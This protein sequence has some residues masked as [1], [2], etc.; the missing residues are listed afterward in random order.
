MPRCAKLLARGSCAVGP[1]TRGPFLFLPCRRQGIRLKA[2]AILNLRVP[3]QLRPPR[4]RFRFSLLCGAG[5]RFLD[6]RRTARQIGRRGPQ[7][8]FRTV[9][10]ETGRTVRIPVPVRRGCFSGAERDGVDLRAR[11][12]RSAGGRHRLLRL[13]RGRGQNP[14]SGRRH[15]SQPR[16]DRAAQARR[17]AGHKSLNRLETVRQLERLGIADLL[18][19]IHITSM[20]FA[21]RFTALRTSWGIPGGRRAR[22][23]DYF[24]RQRLLQQR[25]RPFRRTRALRRVD[26][27]ADLRSAN[28][29]SSPMRCAMPVQASV[30]DSSQDWPQIS[31]EEMVALAAGSSGL[32]DS[33][34]RR[35]CRRNV[36]VLAK[37]PGW[38][39][40]TR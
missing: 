14:Q 33:A 5:L 22:C 23:G 3:T 35:R 28:T 24:A 9:S 21:A 6:R 18:P 16:R 34:F 40:W 13:S 37:R 19:P 29:P 30:V 36:E 25:L 38:D 31:L 15:Q 8:S 17:R 27:S 39:F 7:G 10:D 11:P 20:K 32:R 2:A 1:G 26:R 4:H 12:R